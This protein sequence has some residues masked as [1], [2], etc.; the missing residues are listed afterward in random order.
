M[1]NTFTENY[2]GIDL[3]CSVEDGAVVGLDFCAGERTAKPEMSAQSLW[4]AVSSELAEYF[5]GKRKTFDLPLRYA[6]TEFQRLVWKGLLD[7][8]YGETRSY[9]ELARLIGRPKAARAVGMACHANP[10]AILIPCHRVIGCTGALTG[11]GGGLE[12][13]KILLEL[14]AAHKK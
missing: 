4:E 6:G 12:A 7:I 11:F 1:I 14:E 3:T 10:I 5:S 9:G 13:K 2:L 8:P